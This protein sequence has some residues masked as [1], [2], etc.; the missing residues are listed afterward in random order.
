MNLIISIFLIIALLILIFGVSKGKAKL[1]IIIIVLLLVAGNLLVNYLLISY[2]RQGHPDKVLYNKIFF[3]NRKIT[4]EAY[5]KKCERA[6]DLGLRDSAIFYYKKAKSINKRVAK[7]WYPIFRQRDSVLLRK[8]LLD[9]LDKT[10]KVIN[11]ELKH[12]L[13]IRTKED[14]IEKVK[15]ISRWDSL[16]LSLFDE[17]NYTDTEFIVSVEKYKDI[18][19]KYHQR[20]FPYLRQKVY[21]YI[22]TDPYMKEKKIRKKIYGVRLWG[23]HK[24]Q[25]IFL[26]YPGN[27]FY[28]LPICREQEDD[29]RAL[30][31]IHFKP[32]FYLT[33]IKMI[34]FRYREKTYSYDEDVA[35]LLK[36]IGA[37]ELALLAYSEKIKYITE[38]F[39]FPDI[40]DTTIITLDSLRKY[41]Q[42]VIDSHVTESI[43]IPNLC[44]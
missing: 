4:T 17:Y 8:I 24:D 36:D 15:Q 33:R 40:S 39:T 6:F 7:R 34:G 44:D 29:P 30:V 11:N 31:V 14:L 19:L 12:V 43:R 22:R 27:Q 23:K 16:Y 42:V 1:P 18:L 41:Y 28:A 3:T 21:F 32:Y 10:G 37:D 9:S 25:L 35:K 13:K 26:Y 2:I 20:V 5:L 38:Y